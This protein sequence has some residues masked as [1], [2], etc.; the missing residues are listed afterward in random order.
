MFTVP[1]SSDP[2]YT[3]VSDFD[4]V[5]YSLEFRYN[6]RETCWYLS[7]ADDIGNDIIN[8]IK[9]VCSIPLLRRF[10]DTRLPPGE[11]IAVASGDDDSP[12]GLT[13]LGDGLRVALHYIT[14]AEITAIQ[15]QNA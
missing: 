13:E 11:L 15:A 14:I 8:G 4:G 12:P 2:F 9:I 3:Q 1:T 5:N 7:I 10:S 6:Q